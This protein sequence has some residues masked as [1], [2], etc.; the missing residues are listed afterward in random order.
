MTSPV[1]SEK[2]PRIPLRARAEAAN[3]PQR[4]LTVMV[5]LDV[6]DSMRLMR[7]DENAALRDLAEIRRLVAAPLLKRHRGVLFKEMGDGGLIEFISV[8]DAVRFALDFQ[9][10]MSV[11]NES[12]DRPIQFRAAVAL[13]DVVVEGRERYGAAVGFVVHLQE[14]APAGGVALTHSVR[15]QLSEQLASRF[16][17]TE[18]R[19][20][21]GQHE[22]FEVWIK[23]PEEF[24]EGFAAPSSPLSAPIAGELR[25]RDDRPVLVVTPFANHTGDAA[26]QPMVDGL[27]HEV[28]RTLSQARDYDVI[29]PAAMKDAPTGVDTRLMAME[30]GARYV[31]SGD[32]R[33]SGTRVRVGAQLA[34]AHARAVLWS[35]RFEG[36]ASD[37]FAL[38]DEV[39]SSVAGALHTAIRG[40]EIARSQRKRADRLT[41][42]DHILL[43]LPKFW[44][45]QREDNEAAIA[46]LDEALA[47]APRH[48]LALAFKG[49]C[50]AQTVTYLWSQDVEQDRARALACA[51]EA[52]RL[53]SD[54]ALA[55]TAIGATHTILEVDQARALAFIDRALARDPHLAWAWLRA[56]YA[57]AYAGDP[58]KG[59][60]C[61]ER[62]L[63]LSPFDPMRF[64]I[65]AGIG[66]AHFLLANYSEAREFAERSLDHRP[67]MVWVNRLLATSAAHA[68]DLPAARAAAGRLLAE[69]PRLTLSAV[70]DAIHNLAPRDLER[71]L[72]GLRIAGLPADE[73]ERPAAKVLAFAGRRC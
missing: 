16:R 71:Y 14:A 43:A 19:R 62:A 38:E 61:F 67:G 32:V 27:V 28:T 18:T 9:E 30:I 35:D 26:S 44:S 7:D 70:R 63:A 47:D 15:W 23:A 46:H 39:A 34:E 40:A 4:K 59:L 31:L 37:A 17:R 45:H 11:R 55:M 25:A 52:A 57:H 53:E 50:L 2:S 20:I 66:I 36:D 5:S 73:S 24:P 22:L 72:D 56:G 68:G 8:E 64:N 60:R 10:A 6:A 41:P 33:M 3:R 29:G 54:D 49:W 65:F 21:K 69:N 42:Q 12:A 13:A 58:C 1:V 51:N 48:A